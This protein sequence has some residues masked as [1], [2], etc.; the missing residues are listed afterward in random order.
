MEDFSSE[1]LQPLVNTQF[2]SENDYELV[3]KSAMSFLPSWIS[4]Q[5][6]HK[7]LHPFHDNQQLDFH[8]RKRVVG[9]QIQSEINMHFYEDLIEVHN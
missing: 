9:G 2:E 4:L 5:N 8:E 6:F 3:S 7:N 1:D